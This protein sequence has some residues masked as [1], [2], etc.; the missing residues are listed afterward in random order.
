METLI[1]KLATGGT[2][3]TSAG[4][5]TVTFSADDIGLPSGGTA[6]LTISGGGYSYS[7]IASAGADGTVTFEIPMITSGTSITVALTVKGADGTLLYAGSREQVVRGDS[8]Q[9]SVALTSQ[10]WTLPASIRAVA[11]PSSILYRAATAD[12]VS[13]TLSVEGLDG[14][15]AGVSY[16]W[17]DESGNQLGTGATLIRTANEI[18]GGTAPADEIT[19]TYTVTVSY[20]DAAGAAKTASASASVTVGG[21]VTLP[22]FSI[23]MEVPDSGSTAAPDGSASTAWM[24]VN[25]DDGVKLT[26]TSATGTF[27]GGTTFH[28][29]I[30]AT[31]G[32]LITRTT[33]ASEVCVVSPTDLELTDSSM[34]T[35]AAPTTLTVRCTAKNDRA[36]TDTD[37]SAI[38]QGVYLYCIIPAFTVTITPPA[39]Y[40]AAKSDETDPSNPSFALVD[41]TEAFSFTPVSSTGLFPSGTTFSWSLDINSPSAPGPVAADLPDTTAGED[42]SSPIAGYTGLLAASDVGYTPTYAASISVTCTAHNPHAPADRTGSAH[43]T[44]FTLYSLPDF[45]VVT[46]MPLAA[47]YN[48]DNSVLPTPTVPVEVPI[49]ACTGINSVLNFT[50]TATLPAGEASFPWGS[51]TFPAGSTARWELMANNLTAEKYVTPEVPAP[52]PDNFVEAIQPSGLGLSADATADAAHKVGTSQADAS[53]ISIKCT[54]SNPYAVD[55]VVVNASAKVFRLTVPAFK[56]QVTPPTGIE[57]ETTVVGATATT[58]YKI[59]DADD[60][61]KKFQLKAVPVNSTDTFP[62]GTKFEWKFA[63]ATTFT[64]APTADDETDQIRNQTAGEICGEPGT[65]GTPSLTTASTYTIACRAVLEG[66]DLPTNA[67][68]SI[69][70]Q[71]LFTPAAVAAFLADPSNPAFAALGITGVGSLAQPYKLPPVLGISNDLADP[72]DP[73]SSSLVTLGRAM[74]NSAAKYVD[75]SETQLPD[76]LDMVGAF[77]GCEKLVVPPQLPSDVTSLERTFSGCFNLKTAPEIPAS[78]TN[79][80]ACFNGCSGLQAAPEIPANVTEM[81]QCFCGCISLT[82]NV[83]IKTTSVP[84]QDHLVVGGYVGDGDG[85]HMAFASSSSS[86]SVALSGITV[87]VASTEVKNAILLNC[88]GTSRTDNNF[89]NNYGLNIKVVGVDVTGWP[90]TP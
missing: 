17:T 51:A 31:G 62:V 34:G 1:D 82:G 74:N 71:Q 46:T 40:V 49:F 7:G 10:Y 79:M 65:P 83:V 84:A 9:I 36:D 4:T 33:T 25:L 69:S 61:T 57:S 68:A 86:N 30:E 75:L 85:W 15:P 50:A 13:S 23:S 45:T 6:T 48:A 59:E 70:M 8:V 5:Q 78:V 81:S 53:P 37:A 64:T 26:P 18:T 52:L 35:M 39:G 77:A 21:P 47:D 56:I 11:S 20:T 66:A 73:Y 58:T 24:L 63:G 16:L 19:K 42:A 90:T 60:T 80:K 55:D 38:T 28:W 3:N 41:A 72:S 87:Y 22:A 2:T 32:A 43:A 76:G 14:A 12:S 54:I 88:S 29:E 67:T 89:N 27:P 44:A